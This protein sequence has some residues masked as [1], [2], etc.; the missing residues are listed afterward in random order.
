MYGA[1]VS[2]RTNLFARTRM[3]ELLRK[4]TETVCSMPRGIRDSSAGQAPIEEPPCDVL[5]LRF[6]F[7]GALFANESCIAIRHS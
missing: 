7:R 1:T 4:S 3:T 5:T 6:P 2:P